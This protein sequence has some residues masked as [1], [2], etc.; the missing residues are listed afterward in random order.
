MR[1]AN[2]IDSLPDAICVVDP[3]ANI[4]QWNKQFIKMFSSCCSELKSVASNSNDKANFVRDILH[5]SHRQRFA[6]ALNMLRARNNFDGDVR[7]V[8]LRSTMSYTKSPNTS[9]TIEKIKVIGLQ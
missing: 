4:K 1:S 2:L 3:S 9:G 6:A 5:P 8:A 7:C